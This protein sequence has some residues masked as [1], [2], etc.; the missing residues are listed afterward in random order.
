MKEN[1]GILLNQ[2][3]E[4]EKSGALALFLENVTLDKGQLKDIKDKFIISTMHSSKGLEWRVCYIMGCSSGEFPKIDE[5]NDKDYEEEKR[6]FYVSVSRAKEEL[7]ITASGDFSSFVKE[8]YEEPY[9]NLYK[10]GDFSG[11]SMNVWN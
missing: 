5:Q 3:K 8:V 11:F 6:L 4:I 1:V 10:V 7:Y 9:V 2:I